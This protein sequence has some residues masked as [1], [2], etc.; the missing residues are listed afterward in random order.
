MP[1]T[2]S[3][4]G[5]WPRNTCKQPLLLH[6]RIMRVADLDLEVGVAQ[7]II[8]AAHDVGKDVV[9]ERRHQHAD[10]VGARRGERPRIGVGH[11]AERLD[12]GGDLAAQIFGNAPGSRSA[13]DTVIAP[14]PASLATSAMVGLPPPRR[15]RGFM[16]GSELMLAT[17]TPKR[18][19]SDG[20]IVRQNGG[21]LGAATSA[22]PDREAAPRRPGYRAPTSPFT[23]ERYS[24]LR[25]ERQRCR[26]RLAFAVLQPSRCSPHDFA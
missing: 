2:I 19:R 25:Y 6:A 10:D 18:R 16:V 26:R 7:A 1:E 13:R 8:D 9:G 15:E 11:I 24:R 5:R 21:R 23:P 12:R 3:A 14:T 4:A 20:A 17:L 22:R